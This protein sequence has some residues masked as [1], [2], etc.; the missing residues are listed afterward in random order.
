MSIEKLKKSFIPEDQDAIK[1]WQKETIE[2]LEDRI[3]KN[4][5]DT[6]M[7]IWLVEEYLENEPKEC[8]K[9]LPLLEQVILANPSKM[10]YAHLS[11][12]CYKSL[13]QYERA[14]NFY[15]KAL[16]VVKDKTDE[17]D[18]RNLLI[19]TYALKGD[20]PEM[21]KEAET[22]LDIIKAQPMPSFDSLPEGPSK[23]RFVREMRKRQEGAIK[24]MEERIQKA[25]SELKQSQGKESTGDLQ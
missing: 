18:I 17:L 23:E 8:E 24:G 3:R 10:M 20:M 4:P 11:H 2:W 25:K 19:E 12:Y 7:I 9:A 16:S 5:N 13:N 21:I 14:I 22:T 15:R 1:T 6:G